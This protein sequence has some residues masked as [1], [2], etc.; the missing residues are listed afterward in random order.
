MNINSFLH[1]EINVL[2]LIENL[3]FYVNDF[4]II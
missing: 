4:E 2:K 1:M 3:H